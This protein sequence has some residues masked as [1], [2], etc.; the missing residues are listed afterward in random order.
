MYGE[1]VRYKHCAQN[2][3]FNCN[4]I[5]FFQYSGKT[6]FTIPPIS[7]NTKAQLHGSTDL[8]FRANPSGP[9]APPVFLF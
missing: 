6:S 3:T 2:D 9:S 8:D 4:Q 5:T 7:Q 1:T